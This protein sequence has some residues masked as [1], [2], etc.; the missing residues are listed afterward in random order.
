MIDIA[1]DEKL[2]PAI[3]ARMAAVLAERE[4]AGLNVHFIN[5]RGE[6]DR[7]S[8]ADVA[9]RDKFI[10]SLKREGREIL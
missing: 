1:N 9:T 5:E 4:A 3:R 7:Y 8:F 2:P 6:R 10:R